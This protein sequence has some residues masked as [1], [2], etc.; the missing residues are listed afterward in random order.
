LTCYGTGEVAVDGPP[1]TCPDCYGEGRALS[2]G[3]KIEWR[4]RAMESAYGQSGR[5]AAADVRWLVSE[6]RQTREVLVR[7][8]A[9]C[10]DADEGD[11]LA[12]EI[13]QRANEALKVYLPEL[14]DPPGAVSRRSHDVVRALPREP[15]RAPD[16]SV[17]VTTFRRPHLLPQAIESAKA[18]TGVRTEILVVDDSPEGSA[19]DVVAAAGPDV[20][21]VHRCEP[22][23]GRP[24]IA[25]NDAVALCRGPFLHFLDDDDRLADGSLAM[26]LEALSAS[27]AG[28][29]FGRIVPFGDDARLVAE[30]TLYFRRVAAAAKGLRGRRAFAAHL[31]FLDSLL[32]NSACMVRRSAFEAARGYDATLLCCEDVE[33]YLRIGRARGVVFVDRD[34]LHYR[35]G[36]ASIMCAIR[37]RPDHPSLRAAYALMHRRYQD[38]YGTVE[39]RAL[40][41]LARGFGI[42]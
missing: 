1:E 16:V 34:V 33:L 9:R 37:E 12:L 40:Q 18:Q 29:A 41:V 35:V 36:E 17:I 25:R 8:L 31:L 42:A 21:Y 15:A 3:T 13:R 26:L 2:A 6:L 24:G 32:V 14:A 4:L 20:R 5:E 19:R 28:M 23:G 27:N 22:S 39:Y 30:Q 38:R 7:I 10:Q 11:A